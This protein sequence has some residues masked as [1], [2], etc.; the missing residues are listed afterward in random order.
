MKTIAKP[1]FWTRN[2]ENLSKTLVLQPNVEKTYTKPYFSSKMLRKPTQNHSLAEKQENL[3]KTKK[4]PKT[5]V[6]S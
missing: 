4:T 6:L 1:L 2:I 5:K 3:Q